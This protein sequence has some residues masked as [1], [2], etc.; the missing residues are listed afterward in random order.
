MLVNCSVLGTVTIFSIPLSD[1]ITIKNDE[2]ITKSLTFDIL[3][4]YIWERENNILK[5]LT[6]DASKL[7][8]WR[9][10]VEEVVDVLTEDDIIQKL[11]GKKMSPHF[12]FRNHFNDQLSE[13]KIHIIIQPLPPTTEIPTKRRRIDNWVE[14]TAKDG[15]VDLPP[16]LS[17][18][19]ACEKFR[20]APRNEFEKLLKDLQIGQ[21]I[22]LPSL[23][24]EPKN[25]GEDYQGRSFLITE[26]MIEIW[27]MLASD[28]DRSIKRV[29]SGPVGVGK[30]Y[31]AL[32]LAAK[33]FAEGWLLLYVSDANELVKPDDAKIAKEICMRFLALNRDILT[34]NHFYQMMSLLSRSEE[35]EEKVYQ[36]V[37]S[38]I[39]DDLLKQLKEKTLIVIDEHKILFEPDPPIPH[40]QIRLNPL[41]HLNAW[42]QER[43]GCRVVVTGTAHAKFEQ[44]YL[45][46]GMTNWIIFVSP[47]SSVI[48]NKL[49]SMNNVLSSTKIIRDKVTEITNRVPRELMKLSNGLNDNCGNSKNID[50]SKII[51]FLIQFEQDRNLDFFNV[52]QNYYTH[53]LN[54]TQRYSTRHALASMF[55]PRKEGDIDRDRKGFDHWFVDLGLVYRI[56]FRGRVQHHPLCPAAKNALLQLYKS[57]PLPQHK[58]MCVKDGNMT[59]PPERITN[60]DILF[61]CYEGYPRFDFILGRTFIQVSISNFTANNTKSADIEKKNQ[62]ENYLDNAYGGNHQ[63][64][65]DSST[66]KFIVTRN[67]QKVH[68]FHIVYICGKLGNPNHTGKVK[69]FPDILHI[70]LD[71]LNQKLF[72]DLLLD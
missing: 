64:Y 66:K 3:K 33:A 40:K 47:L 17:T 39:M 24:Q 7:D 16:I 15:L 72:G 68:D 1:K 32:F 26:Q 49:L 46:D 67:G 71:E 63:A 52:A 36:T 6:N 53:H 54:L 65:I 57:I 13:G 28:S 62:I 21:N 48:F 38:N 20:P 11:G 60:D 51:N 69:D 5:Y 58:S 12:L 55:L 27:N 19:L 14:Y 23:G 61:R 50:T 37:A 44:V 4:K 56:K 59:D 2:Y 42:N 70:N 45:K 25:Y 35:N 22:M 29:L 10:D 41:M 8:L 43:K 31:L 30:S 9:V 18:M 34:K